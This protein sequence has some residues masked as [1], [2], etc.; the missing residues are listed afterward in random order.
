MFPTVVEI[1]TRHV[2]IGASVRGIYLPPKIFRDQSCNVPILSK[3][4]IFPSYPS[5][6]EIF[7]IALN[8]TLFHKCFWRV[9]YLG[10]D[11]VRDARPSEEVGEALDIL[12]LLPEV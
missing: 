3:T 9:V 6:F 4:K 11:C 10:G 8:S 5:I 7:K 1:A 2:Q 12:S